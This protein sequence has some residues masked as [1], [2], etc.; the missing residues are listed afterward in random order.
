MMLVVVAGAGGGAFYFARA[1]KLWQEAPEETSK[2][3]ESKTEGSKEDEKPEEDSKEEK[4]EGEA[5]TTTQNTPTEKENTTNTDHATP[6]S[7]TL[8]GAMI[9][10]VL[11]SVDASGDTVSVSAQIAGLNYDAGNGTCVI[12]LTS[13]SGTVRTQSAE[14]LES[15]GNKYCKR[16]DFSKSELASGSWTA[17]VEYKNTTLNYQGK[18]NAESFEI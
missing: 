3:E 18:S 11:P 14:I 9:F 8:T 10:S 13:A 5:S 7:D 2:E 4:P 6:E 15:P 12:T 1:Q 16:V 17:T